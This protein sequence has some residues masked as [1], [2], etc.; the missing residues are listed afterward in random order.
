MVI[1]SCFLCVRVQDNAAKLTLTY[2]TLATFVTFSIDATITLV[3][4]FVLPKLDYCNCLFDGSPMYI[5]E[6]LQKVI[7]QLKT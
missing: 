5:V 7:T 6:R 1:V 2:Y 3:S 4:T